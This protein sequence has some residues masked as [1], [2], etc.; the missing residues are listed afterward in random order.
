MSP[1]PGQVIGLKPWFPWPLSRWRWLNEPVRAERLA[2]LRI[3]I[4]VLTVLD[5]LL[6][7]LPISADIAGRD[8]I[9]TP[10]LLEQRFKNTQRWSLLL[11]ADEPNEV[12]FL[13]CV[14]AGSAFLLALGLFS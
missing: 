11:D 3:G 12:R 7:L 2:A 13:L 1:A 14:W 6:T 10:G 8:S 9:M 4:A 5:V